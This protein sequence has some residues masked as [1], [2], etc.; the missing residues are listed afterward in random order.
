MEKG[1]KG[2][3]STSG[4]QDV[5]NMVLETPEH[6]GQLRE[7]GQFVTPT[8]YFGRANSHLSYEEV[9]LMKERVKFLEETMENMQ[10]EIRTMK[11]LG[12][13]DN[14]ANMDNSRKVN[15]LIHLHSEE[16]GYKND[17]RARELLSRMMVVGPHQLLLLPFNAGNAGCLF[18]KLDASSFWHIKYLILF[19]IF[20]SCH[21]IILKN[22]TRFP[23][24]GVLT[25][26]HSFQRS[27]ESRGAPN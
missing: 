27:I 24:E 9:R 1:K 26:K 16:T 3:L 8:S 13:T 20:I 17:H 23:L 14:D 7:L 6:R 12:Q 4:S 22:S 5:L 11:E 2:A 10:Q 25:L 21:N 15:L 18:G 19:E